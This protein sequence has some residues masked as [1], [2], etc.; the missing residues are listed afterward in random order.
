MKQLLPQRALSLILVLA[1]LLSF[2]VP[3]HGAGHG[4]ASVSFQQV[5][6]S[7]VSADLLTQTTEAPQ[8]TEPYADDDM[9]RVSIV[10]EGRSTIQAGF[11]TAGIA[12]NAEAMAYRQELREAQN[13]VT[14][15]ISQAIGQP[16]D[17][18]WNLTLAA[19]LISANVPYG[20]MDTI[21]S[22]PGVQS[23]L[24]ETC[25]T[26]DVVD[27]DEPA[28]PN[29]ATS[30]EQIGSASAWAAGYTGLGSRIAV[31]DTG[32][33]TDHQSFDAGAFQYSLAYQ[34]GN[35][36]MD[37]DE[38]VASLNLLDADEIASLS[39][40]L[41]V[42]VS[43]DKAYLNAK[44]PFGYNYID[45][46]YDITHDNDAQGAHGSH[47]AGIA[48]A[49]AYIAEEDGSFS[50]ALTSVAVQGV[51]PDAQLI[52]MKV[53][54]KNGGAYD[55]DYMAAI[56]DAIIL[57]CDAVNLSLGSGNPGPS[58][59]A[60]SV[61]QA[62]MEDL[63][64][65][66]T[67]VTMSAGNSGYWAMYALNDSGYLYPDDI[68]MDMVGAP[69]SFTNSLAVASVDNDGTSGAYI[70]VG[71]AFIIYNE[72]QYTNK[73]FT[74]IA[75]TYEYVYID[76]EGI[77]YDWA[78]VGDALKGKVA[79][80]SR[81]GWNTFADKA[82]NAI[83]AGA[84]AVFIYNNRSGT[85]NMDLT[86]YS[87][88]APVAALTRADAQTIK[89]ASNHVTNEIGYSYYTGTMTI[90]AGVGSIQYNSEYYTLSDFSSW[91]V[92]GTLELKPEITA[93]GGSIYSVDGSVA[94][95]NAYMV[96]SGT[97]MSSPQVAGMAAVV[98]Q[99]IQEENLEQKTGL[100]VRQ[101]TQS[102]LMSTAVPFRDAN[103]ET[104]YPVLQ[105]GAGLANVGAAITADSYILMDKSATASWAD[106]KVKVEL[107]D[108]PAREG[109]YT[110]GFTL[111][112]LTDAEKV[113]TLSADFYTQGSFDFGS[114]PELMD[115]WCA[116]MPTLVS[117]TVDGVPLE[118]SDKMAGMDF[119]GDG[120][121]NSADGQALLNH[122]V[123][124]TRGISRMDKADLDADGD[125]DTYDAYLFF[126][127]LG[128]GTAILAPGGSIQ[129]TVTVEL[130]EAWRENLVKFEHGAYIEGYIFATSLADAEGI[131]GTRHS[132]PVLGFFGNWSD[133][134]M[135]DVGSYYEYATGDETRNPYLANRNANAFSVVYDDRPGSSYYLGG[136]PLVADDTYMPE[137]NAINTA[138]GDMIDS[139]SVTTIRNAAA[140]R[141]T[142]RNLT[143]GETYME[144][145]P[146]ALLSAY[147][148]SVYGWLNVGYD[149]D[150]LL[151][152]ENTTEGDRLALELTLAP[153]YYIQPDG[154][155][156]WDR[157]GKGTT[158]TLPLV[159][160]NSA[161]VLTSV[162][163][164]TL[165]NEL[166]VQA[167]D[168][169][170]IAAVALYNKSGSTTYA[171]TGAKQDIEPNTS[172]QYVL[173]L[174]GVNGKRF[175]LQ[176]SDYAMNTTTYLL[177]IQ[178]GE[179]VPL[180]EM[181]AFDL[182]KNYWT[183]FTKT[184]TNNQ[185]TAY[186]SSDLTF[187]AATIAD[188]M[189]LAG[190]KSGDLY[191]MPEDDL[192]ALTLVGNLGTVVTDMAYNQANGKVYGV[193]SG[194]LVEIDKLT[195]QL[196]D[197][198]QIGVHTNTLACD[199]SGTFYCNGYGTGAVYRFTLDT[200][201]SP[202]VL[203]EDVGID[204]IHVQSMEY[205]P[206][207][208]MLCWSSYN[209][210]V[211]H[212]WYGD[213]EVPYAYYFEIN[214]QTGECTKY[215]DMW[216][217]LAALIIPV[218]GSG[219]GSWTT[220]SDQVSGV[221][222]SQSELTVLKNT[223]EAL[224]AT[225][226]PWTATDRTVSWSSADEQIA[227]IDED[228][229]IT[230]LSE[231]TTVITATSNLDPTVSASCTV[232]VSAL[233]V[234]VEGMLQ[235]G[236][237]KSEFFTWNLKTDTTWSAGNPIDTGLISATYSPTANVHYVMDSA[238]GVW[239]MHKVGAD[240]TTMENS[241]ANALS[242]P[243]WDMQ[244]STYYS[245][246]AEA[247]RIVG[248]HQAYLFAP[249]DPMHMDG[250][251]FSLGAYL[252]YI[253]AVTS[254]GYEAYDDTSAGI[255]RDTEHLILIDN[256]GN[257][258]NFW[259]YLTDEGYSAAFSSYPSD[260]P[261]EFPGYSN[262]MYMYCSLVVGTDG[263][264]YLSA[265]NGN[266]N[267]L[268]RM[269]FSEA[270][271]MYHAEYVCEMGKDIWPAVITAVQVN[272]SAGAA[273][274]AVPTAVH[275]IDAET[276][277]A[278]ALTT[279][280]VSGVDTSVLT[281]G[282]ANELR[283]IKE[284]YHQNSDAAIGNGEK[285]ITVNVTT[286]V[287]AT[288]GLTTVT[289]DATKLIL[290]SAVVNGDYSAKLEEDGKLTF[291]YVYLTEIPAEGTIATLTFQVLEAV[292]STV[293][294]EHRQVNN[295]AGSTED[296]QIEFEHANTEIR[297]A[298]EAT[299]TTAGY[300]GDTYCTD[301]GQ[302]V[303][304]GEIIQA[305]GHSFGEWT[306]T[307]AATCTEKGEEI[308]TCEVCGATET[309]ETD[310]IAHN[311]EKVIVAPTCTEQG[312]T[313]YTCHCGD[314]YVDDYVDA[315]GHTFGD[316]TVTEQ[317]TCTKA[318]M[319]TRTCEVCGE[320]ETREI[321]PYCPAE[322][323]T[324]VNT[325]LWYH[326]GVCYVIRKGLMEGKDVGIFAP[327]VNLSRAELV[328]VLYRMAGEPSVEGK[329]H[330]FKDVSADAWYAE[331]VT[332]AFN[333]EVVEGMSGTVFAP[334]R[335]ISREQIALI[336]FRYSD[337]EKVE[338]NALEAYTDASSISN[339]AVDA[340]NW[341][342]AT[343]LIKG[344]TTTTLAPRATAIRAQIAMILMRYNEK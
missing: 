31:I 153:E 114:P 137:R 89:A 219:G 161:P 207:T 193:A 344:T 51:A 251:A 34:A 22:I 20:Q 324:D 319:E 212:M 40:E 139:L 236:E 227:V 296:L 331:A 192:A 26:P 190:T 52:T 335:D 86:G 30:A 43:A 208:G 230:G 10:L 218:Q 74:S 135:Y 320:T 297:D 85:F 202:T 237:G 104:Y 79:L 75:G 132:I 3:V 188:H 29:M 257:V 259:I 293:T 12:Q 181:I 225:V 290:E 58:K 176:V 103:S 38:Y 270:D 214:P 170:Y 50:R 317:E 99:Y 63:T 196:T 327:E 78:D 194:R 154:S 156:Q 62:I 271:R 133:A 61:Y 337:A 239:A 316:W 303:K 111:N 9:I 168:N 47:V 53:F 148:H 336:L 108:D 69:G 144:V 308:R 107:G 109:K 88:D 311:Y 175:M 145:Y 200:L 155:V 301:C 169:Q 39:E 294:V 209:I 163:Y 21:A 323:Y 95:G 240:G 222:V 343:G 57:G 226:Q 241:G 90:S 6:N 261:C 128:T 151:S 333:E 159:V 80:C 102:L 213:R 206:N 23:V 238:D 123:D 234:T 185:L 252:S 315:L 263:A 98:A 186:A 282:M 274:P 28:D 130:T 82:N 15:A 233:D 67:V 16:L 221:Q 174:E 191:V 260:L 286:D 73:P 125:I 60:N 166:L 66:D 59:N 2:Q 254:L 165:N 269:T 210:E 305:K 45:G 232:T 25:Y 313:T 199:P 4:S 228:G 150:I 131:A 249:Q 300:T 330:P 97:S 307:R 267:E 182:D 81:G 197:I 205:N 341:A 285:T 158:F 342:V 258:F 235:N 171:Y 245:E 195:A 113:F 64:K 276:V 201:E 334:D 253:T 7:A 13:S 340:M 5:D 314:T 248:I 306:V 134:S 187:Y 211:V 56:E 167:S 65:S 244:Y 68:S 105:Q 49:N 204:T 329:T 119:N 146:G 136:N 217:E 322:A 122:V 94:S 318:G 312:Y 112:N 14:T 299:C 35:S 265:F 310:M 247:E 124:P 250:K 77:S 275:T 231:G 325:K 46:D 42:K 17:V 255:T 1:L 143:T 83:S 295:T 262:K 273:A 140:S 41:N 126:R 332:W 118:P 142:A 184:T 18:A 287:A 284:E 281:C 27:T 121:L 164:D 129:V 160:D 220:P 172:A 177:E 76:G 272:G 54:G 338:E 198:G 180:P 24:P 36:G 179:E 268:Y 246:Q 215:N 264:L 11:S 339:D 116:D 243:L 298:V 93:P 55:S 291:G 280:L 266:T 37:I 302:L 141:F 84:I 242:L 277:S 173:D 71:D 203:V 178:I 120:I 279:C 304:K 33:D 152:P 289:Y 326:E 149:M 19:N 101:L 321:P 72:T 70:T 48:T 183:S 288:N 147:Y 157:L 96:N 117:W 223:Q 92:P 91:G 189:V 328:T 44:L 110:F 115:I 292:E 138:R 162:A 32:T 100:T 283:A 224:S 87:Y 309:R 106:G 8:E 216:D 127:E 256:L 229:V 278:E